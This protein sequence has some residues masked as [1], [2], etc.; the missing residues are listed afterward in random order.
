MAFGVVRNPLSRAGKPVGRSGI[1]ILLQRS[2]VRSIALG[3]EK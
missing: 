1:L 3:A 2:F